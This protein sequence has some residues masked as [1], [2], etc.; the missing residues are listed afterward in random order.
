MVLRQDTSSLSTNISLALLLED[1]LS[2]QSKITTVHSLNE[3]TYILKPLHIQ[4]MYKYSL[5][6]IIL[7]NINT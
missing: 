1:T 7:P 2:G 6:K 3:I 4:F 5:L